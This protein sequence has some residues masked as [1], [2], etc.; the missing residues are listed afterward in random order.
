[1]VV[2]DPDAPGSTF[3]HWLVA[4]LPPEEATLQDPL[5]TAAVEGRNDFDDVGWSAPCPPTGDAPHT[6]RFRLLAVADETGL[7][8]GFTA[9]DLED[10]IADRLVAEGVHTG[11]YGR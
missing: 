11:R 1:M 6:Y 8:H 10:A 2:D 3:V 5:P 4:G 9:Q 7:Q